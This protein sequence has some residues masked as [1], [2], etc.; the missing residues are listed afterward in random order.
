MF[1][2]REFASSRTRVI[3]NTLFGVAVVW[4]LFVVLCAVN[5]LVDLC[6]FLV[7]I[8]ILILFVWSRLRS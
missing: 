3:P 2:F 5:E 6:V 7:L 8:L 4:V 1:S